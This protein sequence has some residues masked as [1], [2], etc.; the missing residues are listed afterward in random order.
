MP[1]FAF[2]FSVLAVVAGACVPEVSIG[3]Q[4]AEDRSDAADTGASFDAPTPT[5]GE[6]CPEWLHA[7]YSAL[8]PDGKTYPTYHPSVDS[9][10]GCHIRP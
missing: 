5:A 7:S 9:R 3:N 6:P 2:R 1:H 4:R 10:Y 8:G